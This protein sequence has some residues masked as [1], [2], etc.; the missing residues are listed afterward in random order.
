M[1]DWC[2]S[3]DTATEVLTHREDY[4][5]PVP[6]GW[7]REEEA[8]WQSYNG[9]R[10]C[11]GLRHTPR[12]LWRRHQG[13]FTQPF[14]VGSIRRS[15]RVELAEAQEETRPDSLRQLERTREAELAAMAAEAEFRAQRAAYSQQIAQA[16]YLEHQVGVPQV[17]VAP[18]YGRPPPPPAPALSPAPHPGLPPALPDAT[19]DERKRRLLDED[20]E[21]DEDEY[22][23]DD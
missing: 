14:P 17:D 12:A 13:T 18:Y 9:R 11:F 15:D 6:P 1:R 7:T 5:R 3:C 20:Y 23:Y 16:A 19:S 21:Y 4:G 2:L 8:A 10:I 22:E